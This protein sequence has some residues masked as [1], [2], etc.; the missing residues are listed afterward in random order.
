MGGGLY[1]VRLREGGH[2]QSKTVRGPRAL[3]ERIERKL[4]SM[5][6][7]NRCLDIK[8]EVNFRMSALLNRYRDEY[9]SKKKSADRERSVRWTPLFGQKIGL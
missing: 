8:R 7:E 4:M 2:N 6:D 5:R 1:T 3:A 9:V